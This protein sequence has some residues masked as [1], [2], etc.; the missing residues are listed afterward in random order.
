VEIAKS[1]HFKGKAL[2]EL[3]RFFFEQVEGF[4][5]S[6]NVKSKTEEID[7]V[8]TN[9]SSSEFWRKER[10]FL[11]GECKNMVGKSGKNECVL[12]EK[13][14]V[15][16]RVAVTTGFFISWNGFTRSFVTENLR[17]S[18]E[19]IIIPIDGK[20]IKEAIFDGDIE[21]HLKTWYEKAVML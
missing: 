3:I 11:I 19:R 9:E 18:R 13:K 7:F 17:G 16:R 14:I 2:E 10:N 5:V 21:K 20:Q 4:K 12:F 6:T 8:V 1:P 15:N